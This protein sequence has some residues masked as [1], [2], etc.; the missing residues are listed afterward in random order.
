MAPATDLPFVLPLGLRL[1][2]V[3]PPSGVR[4]GRLLSLRRGPKGPLLRVEGVSDVDAASALCGREVLARAVDLPPEWSAAAEPDAETVGLAIV[5]ETRGALGEVVE[6]IE[7]GANDV[8]VV[9]GPLGEVLL[10][11]IAEVVLSVDE[12]RRTARVRLLPGLLPD[13]EEGGAA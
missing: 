9:E 7:T 4:S 1:W 10:P 2:F 13:D 5:D 6:V 11:V 8:W 3:P 12:V